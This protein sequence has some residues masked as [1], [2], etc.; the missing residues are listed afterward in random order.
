MVSDKYGTKDDPYCYPGTDLLR[1]KLHIQNATL[2]SA[3]E[4]EFSHIA[5]LEI[6]DQPLPFTL[7]SLKAIHRQLFDDIYEWAGETRTI[8]ISKGTTRFCNWQRIEPEAERLFSG[9]D[10]GR[11]LTSIS[12]PACITTL[13]EFYCELNMVH[14]F[15]E[16][17][18]RA[19][20]VLLEHI[21]ASLGGRVILPDDAER[22][23]QANIAGVHGDYT[24]MAEILTEC[25]SF[26]GSIGSQWP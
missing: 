20:R 7:D 6:D 13:A 11:S 21:V 5:R 22:W 14:P 17:N 1:N 26:E 9:I 10:Y 15:R 3:A 19:Q 16:G 18:G 4:V 24:L 23:L 12:P 2:L 25:I 8:D